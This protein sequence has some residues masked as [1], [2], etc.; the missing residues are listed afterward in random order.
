[1]G[2][3]DFTSGNSD[4]FSIR[5]SALHVAQVMMG[6]RGGHSHVK[7]LLADAR[8]IEV[9]LRGHGAGIPA[10]PGTPETDADPRNPNVPSATDGVA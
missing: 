3:N 6:G 5:A 2:T 7:D 4:D 8:A 9:Y 10:S 1:M